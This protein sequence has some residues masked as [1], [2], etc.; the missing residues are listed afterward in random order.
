MFNTL[1]PN[2]FKR[3]YEH[4]NVRFTVYYSKL[5]T[6]HIVVIENVIDDVIKKFQHSFYPLDAEPFIEISKTIKIHIFQDRNKY[7]EYGPKLDIIVDNGGITYTRVEGKVSTS[8]V[9]VYMRPNV[10]NLRHEIVHALMSD[11]A[12]K[13]PAVLA[14]GIADYIEHGEV[15]STRLKHALLKLGN[16]TDLASILEIKTTDLVYA[17]GLLLV[18]FFE[19]KHPH[20]IDQLLTDITLG[21]NASVHGY[22][23]EFADWLQTL[24][25]PLTDT[26]AFVIE[27][28]S[29]IHNGVREAMIV[30]T[31]REEVG[32]FPLVEFMFFHNTLRA[33]CHG[34]GDYYDVSPQYTYLKV[35]ER[36]NS[37][38][39]TLC[40][41]DGNS[42]YDTAEFK[43]QTN[44][45]FPTVLPATK[46]VERLTQMMHGLEKSK[47]LELQ[48]IDKRLFNT[49]WIWYLKEIDMRKIEQYELWRAYKAGDVLKI[50]TAAK[51]DANKIY[52]AASVYYQGKKIGE[53]QSATGL[54]TENMTFVYNDSAANMHV[55]YNNPAYITRSGEYLQFVSDVTGSNPPKL[56]LNELFHIDASYIDADVFNRLRPIIEEVPEVK[57]ADS[58]YRIERG[59]LLDCRGTVRVTDDVY[60]AILKKGD[61]IVTILRYVGMYSIG[62]YM[63]VHDFGRGQR[64]QFPSNVKWLKLIKDDQKMLYLVPWVENKRWGDNICIDP[65]IIHTYSDGHKSGMVDVTK[66]PIG[67]LFE[68]KPK[69]GTVELHLSD[70]K[71][72][73][74]MVSEQHT[75]MNDIFLSADYNYSFVDFLATRTPDIHQEE[76]YFRFGDGSTAYTNHQRIYV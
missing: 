5:T 28:G 41:V 55:K 11:L 50:A 4:L 73:G 9:F 27:P 64:Y 8:N 38:V 15:S 67:T 14:E 12:R 74:R 17:A 36:N 34:T 39:G 13:L 58:E 53:L 20:Y 47:Q 35:H 57:L 63:F 51:E 1:F 7:L 45:M 69:H 60:E 33:Y 62:E 25:L 10:H 16:N 46:Q 23:N 49:S 76:D 59:N 52:A 75:F 26:D 61:N 72:V 43:L 6:S 31:G 48:E 66:Y 42:Y 40:D 71:Y 37:F 29:L 18:T 54:F 2:A 70:G 44:R 65:F 30:N 21:L 56:K 3:N 68:C 32:Y 19:Q 24:E 22:E